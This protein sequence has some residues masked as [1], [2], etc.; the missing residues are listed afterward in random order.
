MTDCFDCMDP[1]NYAA[2]ALKLQETALSAEACLFGIERSLRQA[3]NLPTVIKTTTAAQTITSGVLTTLNLQTAPLTFT[4]SEY[5][6]GNSSTFQL[7]PA[8]VWLI[9]CYLNA[10]PTGVVDDNTYR[11]L[12]LVL[13]RPFV[14]ST[15]PDRYRCTTSTFEAGQGS[16]DMMLTTTVVAD[17]TTIPFFQFQHGNTSSTVNIASGCIYWA[18][19]LSDQIALKAV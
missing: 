16:M 13:R 7:M 6:M 15:D 3:A 19:R 17:G 10:A 5:T 4:N 9:G 14:P 2:V 11:Q 8:G 1:A 18:N 12:H